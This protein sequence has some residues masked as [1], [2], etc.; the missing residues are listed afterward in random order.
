MKIE[1]W[2]NPSKH[3]VHMYSCL[4]VGSRIKPPDEDQVGPDLIYS[5]PNMCIPVQVLGL[6][7]P[8]LVKT[9]PWINPIDHLIFLFSYFSIVWF[10]INFSSWRPSFRLILQYIIC[11][12]DM[13]KKNVWTKLWE[14]LYWKKFKLNK[15]M[16]KIQSQ[17]KYFLRCSAFHGLCR[18]L[19]SR[20]SR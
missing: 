2:V 19:P 17:E 9:R 13:I 8:F 14:F 15:Q 11:I 6:R 4:S 1:A 18:T 16:K 5:T 3:L 7:L 12:P 20:S 10:R